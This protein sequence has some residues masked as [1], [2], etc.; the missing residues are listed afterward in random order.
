MDNLDVLVQMSRKKE[1]VAS[2]V[3][4]LA[5]TEKE[6][7]LLVQRLYM[8]GYIITFVYD[9]LQDLKWSPNN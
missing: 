8:H 4:S 7:V 2:F 9:E 6:Q 5:K 1:T 3:R